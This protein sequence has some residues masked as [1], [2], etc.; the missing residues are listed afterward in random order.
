MEPSSETPALALEVRDLRMRYGTQD[1]LAGVTFTAQRGEVLALLGPNGAGKTTTIEI[2]EGFRVRSSGT[3]SVLG[4]DPERG[5]EAWRARVGVV[6][7][8]WRDHRF[9]RVRELLVYLARFYTPFA[10]AEVTRPWDVD[11][12]IDVVGLSKS[13]DTKIETLSGGQRRRLD[14]AI[15]I[16]G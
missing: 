14:V 7:Q 9:W 5:N 1:V 16:V 11:E 13:A 8:S 15:G 6:L 3:V 12:L 10:T 2:L 4:I